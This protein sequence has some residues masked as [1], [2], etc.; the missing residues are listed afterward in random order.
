MQRYRDKSGIITFRNATV[1]GSWQWRQGVPP[2]K[3]HS[4]SRWTPVT[5]WTRHPETFLC[6]SVILNS[7]CRPRPTSRLPSTRIRRVQGK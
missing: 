7:I 4:A 2:W 6:T 5:S 1:R 3:V